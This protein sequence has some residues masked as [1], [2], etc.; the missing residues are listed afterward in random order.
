[1]TP[2]LPQS[3]NIQRLANQPKDLPRR[4]QTRRASV[5]RAL[6]KPGRLLFLLIILANVQLS[7]G[8]VPKGQ[9][10]QGDV[11]AVQKGMSELEARVQEALSAMEKIE[12]MRSGKSYTVEVDGKLETGTKET[13]LRRR[14]SQQITD[15][16]LSSGCGDYAIV[17]EERMRESGYE[18]MFMDTVQVSLSSLIS[19]FAGHALVAV[20]TADMPYWFLVDPTARRILSIAWTGKEDMVLGRYW[21]GF[22]GKVSQY[23]L[24]GPEALKTFYRK[25]LDTVPTDVLNRNVVGLE[26]VV[27]ESLKTADGGYLNPRIPELLG[28]VP[29]VLEAAG[30][31][32]ARSIEIRLIPGTPDATSRMERTTEGRWVCRVGLKSDLGLGFV[33]WAAAQVEQDR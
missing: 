16:G 26:F 24:D 8:P 33:S 2:S 6:A 30:V 20:K 15:S 19:N 12:A 4:Q 25:T 29:L 7:C 13:F 10:D 32:P 27:D 9:R 18:T 1:M 28:R 23:P 5:Y 11:A 22:R 17:F 14:T 21:V 31:T 3:P